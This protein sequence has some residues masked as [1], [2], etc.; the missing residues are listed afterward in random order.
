VRR[1]ILSLSLLFPLAAQAPLVNAPVAPEAI[2]IGRGGSA[3]GL[4]ILDCNG[5]GQ[6]TGTLAS[7]QF[8][9]NPN[10]GRPGVFPILSPG[11]SNRDAGGAG[12]T[13]LVEDE[14]GSTV[15]LPGPVI[16]SATDLAIGQP[17]DLV[18]NNDNVNRWAN[19][20]N[21]VNPATMTVMPGN[22][23][24]VAP[25][26][27]PPRL[28]FPSP[29]PARGIDGEEPTITSSGPPFLPGRVMTTAPPAIRSPLNPLL[30]GSFGG[31][32]VGPQ[33]PPPSPPPPPPFLPFTC[34]QQIG[35][36][37]YVADRANRR[38]LAVNSN[39]MTVLAAI[40]T[41]DP[42]RLAMSPN[43]KWLAVSNPNANTVE[44]IDVEPGSATFHTVVRTVAVGRQPAGL[45]WQPES[46]DLLVCNQGDH[47]VSIV[48]VLSLQVRDT[49]RRDV[50]APIDVVA[51]CR[52][53]LV[54]YDTWVWFAFVLNGDG[55]V[56]LY[57]SGPLPLGADDVVGLATAA[58]FRGARA[59]QVDTTRLTP[60]CWIA[61]QD[62]NGLGQLSR[63]EMVKSPARWKLDVLQRPQV[64]HR[65]FAVTTRIGGTNPT[66][67]VPDRLSG[68]A[69]IDLAFDDVHNLGA[70][71]DA[72]SALLP[73]LPRAR[74]SGK[75]LVKLQGATAVP[76]A[77]P[78]FVVAALG[79][80]G[81]VDVFELATGRR[82]ATRA[83]PGVQALAHYWR[84]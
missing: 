71:P 19:S 36:F 17:L 73:W 13:T 14:F 16:G 83:V 32:F 54:G 80:T 51:S 44:V 60:S 42:Y 33:P 27:N 40:P 49:L 8:P 10:V 26:P 24:S 45:A 9:R 23:I 4:S 39:R 76:P 25:H 28:V 48:S 55:S 64:A 47:T 61:H 50:R 68:N 43:L 46:E 1:A 67:P 2:Y 70:L 34:R 57:V 75:G 35:H 65:C 3:P 38:V 82:V 6:G 59:L 78:R 81:T 5:L 11:T 74:H 66:T 52:Q 41:A 21:Q 31:V 53:F 63:L 22:T 15:L 56:A 77:T 12:L 30:N 72:P 79:D 29:N 62:G 84:Q 37:L 69:P 18:L 7:S 20:G 58:P